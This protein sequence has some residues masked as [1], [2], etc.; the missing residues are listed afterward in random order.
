MPGR[1]QRKPSKDKG[2]GIDPADGASPTLGSPPVS[3]GFAGIM[4]QPVPEDE[5]GRRRDS[6][7]VLIWRPSPTVS[8]H[9]FC[10]RP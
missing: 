6:P 8:L 1:A 5:S 7:A 2:H 9:T 3:P 10:K 4:C